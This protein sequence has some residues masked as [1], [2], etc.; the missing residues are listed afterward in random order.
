MLFL[1]LSVTAQYQHYFKVANTSQQN[2]LYLISVH[3]H[4]HMRQKNLIQEFWDVLTM[5]KTVV[6]NMIKSAIFG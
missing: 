3:L 5:L 6:K 1:F 4:I 2:V